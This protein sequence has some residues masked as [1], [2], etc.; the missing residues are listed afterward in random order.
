MHIQSS[1][2]QGWKSTAGAGKVD[3]LTLLSLERGEE[4]SGVDM[5]KLLT[6]TSPG[7]PSLTAGTVAVL[8][9][10]VLEWCW[11]GFTGVWLMLDWIH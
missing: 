3:M 5:A 4:I 9:S 7:T 2:C 10:L 8:G 6:S 11:I 1:L